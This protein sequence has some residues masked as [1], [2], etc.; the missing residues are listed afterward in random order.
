[1]ARCI[2]ELGDVVD[3][4][5]CILF[6]RKNVCPVLG[7]VNHIRRKQVRQ[8]V[9]PGAIEEVSMVVEARI[10][11]VVLPVPYVAL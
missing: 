7:P 5:I 11:G 9:L 4:L 2:Q 8:G 10:Q 6:P 3:C 1:M